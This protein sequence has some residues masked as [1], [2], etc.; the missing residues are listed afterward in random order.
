[1]RTES[2]LTYEIMDGGDQAIVACTCWTEA[3]PAIY[4]LDTHWLRRLAQER[5]LVITNR[6]G[7]AGSTGRADLDS[8]ILGLGEV[9]DEIGTPAVLLGGCEAAVVP[10][11]FAAREP[12]RVRALIVVNGTARFAA[13][14]DYVGMPLEQL[15]LI[16]NAVRADWEGFFRPFLSEVA[17]MPWTDVDTL[18]GLLRQFVTGESLTALFEGILGA[19]VRR[20]LPKIVVPTLVIHSTEDE[21]IPFPQAQ[22]LAAH[23]AKARVHALQGARHHINPSYNDEIVKAV[24]GFLGGQS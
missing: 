18:F 11:A 5:T 17:P 3:A 13:D 15:R 1:M 8:E 7:F 24:A 6:R 19:D 14:E 12:E 21:V 2:G 23:I 9:V 4:S 20:E 22:Y 10:I 16:T